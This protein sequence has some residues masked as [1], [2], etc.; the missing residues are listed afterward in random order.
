MTDKPV[1]PKYDRTKPRVSPN[2]PPRK[3]GQMGAPTNVDLSDPATVDMI[4][5]RIAGGE[6]IYKICEELMISHVRI[7]QRMAEDAQF[8][9][10]ISR[11][12]AAQQEAE[13]DKMIA[14]A[15]A[16]NEDNWQVA[17]LR[18]WARQWRAGKLAPKKYGD[19]L[20]TDEEGATVTIT[21]KGGLPNA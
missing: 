10:K 11:A 2:A 13:A 14:I 15:D 20:K 18:I 21:V 12:R 1:K 3:P 19:K 8:D 17:K 16:A 9:L 7:Y 6:A 4:C 5:Q